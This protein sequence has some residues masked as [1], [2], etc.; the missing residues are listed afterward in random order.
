MLIMKSEKR[1]KAEHWWNKNPGGRPRK[2]KDG[3]D[4]IKA[5]VEYFEWVQENPLHEWKVGFHQGEATKVQVEK[6]RPMT[7]AALC[8]HLGITLETWSQYRRKKEYSDITQLVDLTI[9]NQ[10]L[11]GAAADLFNASIIA[12]DL[13]L[14]DKR[15]NDDTLKLSM[16]EEEINAKL[17]AAGVDVDKLK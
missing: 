7:T 11:E 17:R 16:S 15:E 1:I 4:L 3:S 5:C 6:L 14:V 8:L 12:R 9:R 2:Y 10:K 13:G